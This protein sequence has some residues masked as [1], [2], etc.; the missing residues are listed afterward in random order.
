MVQV[1]SVK[2]EFDGGDM[3]LQWDEYEEAI[4][5]FDRHMGWTFLHENLNDRSKRA[6][7]VMPGGGHA[8]FTTWANEEHQSRYD[9]HCRVCFRIADLDKNLEYFEKH[10]IRYGERTTLPDG[11]ETFDIQA[12]G[13][14]RLTLIVHP[15][16][17]GKFPDSR[18]IS[19]DST[20]I[21]LGVRN[22]DRAVR[23]YR[24]HMGMERSAFAVGEQ[25]ALLQAHHSYE[26]CIDLAWLEQIPEDEPYRE[27]NPAA[28]LYFLVRGADNFIRSHSRFIELG[29]TTSEINGDP[30]SWASYY[31]FDP[32]GNRIN[33]WIF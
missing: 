27:T 7:F 11:R 21:R 1:E 25:F 13:G 8:N 32:D 9:G 23:W 22:I 14:L 17:N 31:V 30:S 4:Q 28:R 6:A 2:F 29:A 15:E 26:G 20:P 12:G 10:G 33:V 18:I 5:W 24:D 3:M 16:W 19:F